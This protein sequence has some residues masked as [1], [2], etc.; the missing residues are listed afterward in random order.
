MRS[1]TDAEVIEKMHH[2]RQCA[3]DSSKEGKGTPRG[4]GMAGRAA[5]EWMRWRAEA[6][7]RGLVAKIAQG[8]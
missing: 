7:K 6:V 4:A 1:F 8:E 5:D 3:R 2:H